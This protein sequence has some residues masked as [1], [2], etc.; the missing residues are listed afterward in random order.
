MTH[1][2][3]LVI[4]AFLFINLVNMTELESYN[5]AEADGELIN[6]EAKKARFRLLGPLSKAHNIIVHIRGSG[7]RTDYFR[8]LARRMILINNYTRWN[9]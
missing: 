4:Q 8:K 7:H 2:I 9:N 1:I 3:N 6:E 5:E